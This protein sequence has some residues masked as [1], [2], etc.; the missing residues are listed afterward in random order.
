MF[1]FAFSKG[2]GGG[3]KKRTCILQA[4]VSPAA[5]L[6]GE[7]LGKKISLGRARIREETRD[8]CSKVH[9]QAKWVGRLAVDGKGKGLV[10]PG[11]GSS[12][13]PAHGRAAWCSTRY[14]VILY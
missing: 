5:S 11:Q 13:A 10:H 7:K 12:S 3:C 4:D 9:E 6:V 8:P 1:P 14:Y 2:L